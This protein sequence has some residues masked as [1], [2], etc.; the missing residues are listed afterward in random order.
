VLLAQLLVGNQ[1]HDLNLGYSGPR[2]ILAD[3]EIS[4]QDQMQTIKVL[5]PPEALSSNPSQVVK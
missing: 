2:P 1:S 4:T 5:F 3:A